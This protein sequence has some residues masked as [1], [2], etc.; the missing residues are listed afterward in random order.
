[1][2]LGLLR[3]DVNVALDIGALVCS[4][5]P[6]ESDAVDYSRMLCNLTNKQTQLF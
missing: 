4:G 5:N 3:G 2:G 1:M 6:R